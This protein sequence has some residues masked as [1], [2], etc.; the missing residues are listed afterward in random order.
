MVL[1]ALVLLA[2]VVL[3]ARRFFP[4]RRISWALPVVLGVTIV[5]VRGLAYVFADGAR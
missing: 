5:V 3:V 2:V 1:K 4:H